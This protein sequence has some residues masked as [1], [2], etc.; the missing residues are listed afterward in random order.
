MGRVLLL[1]Q[2]QSL[3][4]QLQVSSFVKWKSILR[5]AELTRVI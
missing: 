3:G 4:C 5:P 1:V 2:L